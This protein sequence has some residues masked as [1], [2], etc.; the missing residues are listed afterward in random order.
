MGEAAFDREIR[1][2]KMR[3]RSFKKVGEKKAIA[4]AN[5]AFQKVFQDRATKKATQNIGT[6][7]GSDKLMTWYSVPLGVWIAP[8]VLSNRYWNAFGCGDPFVGTKVAPVLELNPPLETGSSNTAT[9]LLIDDE[10]EIAVAHTGRAG[11]GK[12]GVGKFAFRQYHPYFDTVLVDG[13]QR[14]LYL[15][16]SLGAADEL[17]A[18][19]AD[20]VRTVRDFKTGTTTPSPPIKPAFKPEFEGA[21]TYTVTANRTATYTHGRI[22]NALYR[23]LSSHGISAGRTVAIDLF[24]ESSA[25]YSGVIFE[26][27]TSADTQS[28]YTCIGQLMYLAPNVMWKKVAVLPTEIDDTLVKRLDELG[29]YVLR[30]DLPVSG[31]PSFNINALLDALASATKH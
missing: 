11:G 25:K 24:A 8:N 9:L 7:G 16:G 14:E 30:Y 23:E 12:P 31:V 26:A 13:K 29:I 21:T 5:T 20:F 1:W 28:V 27:K 22:V 4:Q 6:P 2:R 10:G 15:L 19:V 18:N 3:M 17:A